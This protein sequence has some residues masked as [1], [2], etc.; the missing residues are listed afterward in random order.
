MEAR[1]IQK[2]IHTSVRKLQLVADLVRSLKPR[3]AL[4]VLEFTPKAAAKPLLKA[5]GT[6]LA[7]AKVQNLDVEKLV[8]KKLEINEG[9]TMKRSMFQAR[10][11]VSPYAK[12]TSQIKIVL[13]EEGKTNGSKS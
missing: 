4:E 12:R 6:T 5:I 3:K 8:F 11:R 13:S 1:T 7:N 2:N 9:P 10:G